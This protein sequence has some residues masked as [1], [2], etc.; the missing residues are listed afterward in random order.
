MESHKKIIINID[1]GSRGN[2]GPAAFGVIFFDQ[3]GRILKQYSQAIG[4]ATNN[5]AEYCGL[6][7]CLKKAKAIFGK[8]KLADYV[9]EIRSDSEL[10]VRQMQ[11]RYKVNGEKIQPLF[12]EAWNLLIGFSNVEFVAV[13][14]EQNIK[15]DQ[16]VN[17]VLDKDKQQKVSSLF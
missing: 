5:E 7:F 2:P 9:F 14:R 15:A 10:L 4:Q 12:L 3:S 11:H 13:P 1:G 6:I 17:E 16:L 8:T